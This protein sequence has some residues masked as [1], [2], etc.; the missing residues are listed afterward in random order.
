MKLNVHTYLKLFFVHYYYSKATFF[1]PFKKTDLYYSVPGFDIEFANVTFGAIGLDRDG[2]VS[3]EA[4]NIGESLSAICQAEL[5]NQN[6]TE[7]SINGIINLAFQDYKS[8][9]SSGQAAILTLLTNN[10]KGNSNFSSLRPYSI[11]LTGYF[12]V[13]DFGTSKINSMA[14]NDF[15]IPF[16]TAGD[17]A[18]SNPDNQFSG[19][20]PF[21]NTTF[22]QILDTSE[23]NIF[24]AVIQLLNYFN[25][26]LVGSV[27]QA[28]TFGYS[29]QR[30]AADYSAINSTPLF[31][32][33][34]VYYFKFIL[35]SEVSLIQQSVKNFCRCVTDKAVMQVIVLWMSSTAA[36]NF[37]TILKKGCKAAK[38]WTFIVSDD[39]QSPASLIGPSNELEN[40]LLIRTNGPW[41]YKSFVE[42][43]LANSSPLA[44]DTIKATL[45]K[46]LLLY[47]NCKLRAEEG[48]QKCQNTGG[49][50]ESS[51]WCDLDILDSDPYSV[52][53]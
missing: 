5:I 46:F 51:C 11:N 25:W 21:Q 31:A 23:Y 36:I 14:G 24:S 6:K 2:L 27:Y 17:L 47:Y 42:N 22:F 28:N 37:I 48:M 45:N 41:N 10:I 43:C 1:D 53:I 9:Q 44:I 35:E 19:N 33:N 40:A 49:Q 50:T 39:L 26:T 15:E 4:F 34:M 52:N 3:A 29:K 13:S 32:C 8:V 7:Y 38:N 12:G 18:R 20:F 30:Q 16:I